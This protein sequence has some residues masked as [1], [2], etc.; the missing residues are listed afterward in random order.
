[1]FGIGMPELLLVMALAVVF[2]GPKK[3]PDLA[4]TM[5]RGMREFR[6]A[7]NGLKQSLDLNEARVISPENQNG[8]HR[9]Q[10]LEANESPRG[11]PSGTE[12]KESQ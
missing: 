7:I 11:E 5:G 10:T 2:I 12:R 8:V 4:R 6:D 1:M 9:K 3:L